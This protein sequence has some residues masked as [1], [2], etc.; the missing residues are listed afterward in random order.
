[1]SVLDYP[2]APLH[3]VMRAT[4]ARHPDRS[5]MTFKGAAQIVDSVP[6]TPQGKFCAGLKQQAL[7]VRDHDT[8]RH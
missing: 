3:D 4:A 7:R 2:D 5:A 1:V 8:P 6:R